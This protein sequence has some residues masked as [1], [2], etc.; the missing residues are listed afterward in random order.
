MTDILKNNK[1]LKMLS[2]IEIICLVL[3]IMLVGLFFLFLFCRLKSLALICADI[4]LAPAAT[5]LIIRKYLRGREVG[6]YAIPLDNNTDYA[7]IKAKLEDKTEE[8]V[9]NSENG[10]AA[11]MPVKKR[12]Y[13]IT[14]CKTADFN[15]KQYY[16][17]RKSVNKALN[18][19]YNLQ[20]SGSI[21][22]VSAIRKLNIL[23]VDSENE[24]LRNSLAVPADQYVNMASAML[25]VTVANGR[26][27]IPGYAGY[28]LGSVFVYDE[29][30]KYT[31]DLFC[32]T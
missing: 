6:C 22:K 26:L 1:K 15:K 4:F 21:S 18:K 7:A 14:L 29:L 25:N 27:F 13:R 28:D 11:R 9:S 24:S 10:F 17:Q 19:K 20:S 23:F 2:V 8:Y 30:V 12:F 31:L 16:S 32:L 5:M 3:A